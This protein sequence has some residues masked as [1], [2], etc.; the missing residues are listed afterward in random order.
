MNLRTIEGTNHEPLMVLF[1]AENSFP[2]QERTLN[3]TPP[4]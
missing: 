1:K 3:L 4:Y 2:L